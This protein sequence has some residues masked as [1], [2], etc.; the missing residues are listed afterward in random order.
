MPSAQWTR[1]QRDVAVGNARVWLHEYR[2]TGR[3]DFLSHAIAETTLALSLRGERMNDL[4][5]F[6]RTGPAPPPYADE[7]F[8][9]AAKA[10]DAFI[11]SRVGEII[12]DTGCTA[13]SAAVQALRELN[14]EE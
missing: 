7:P 3:P 12:R 13:T 4:A 1:Y 9:E 2:R 6:V 10:R 14:G 11:C 5:T 8:P